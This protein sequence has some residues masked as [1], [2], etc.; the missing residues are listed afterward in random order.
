MAVLSAVTVIEVGA[1]PATAFCG[2]LLADAGARVIKIEP[3]DGDPARFDGPRGRLEDPERSPFFLNLNTGKQ[4]VTLDIETPAGIEVLRRL[5][6]RADVLLESLAPGTLEARGLAYDALRDANPGLLLASIT[7]Y[8]QTGPYRDYVATDITLFASSGAMYREGL[9]DREPL[10][11]GG[12][13][14]RTYPGNLAAGFIVAALF[15]RRATGRGDWLDLAEMDAWAAHPNQISR[16]LQTEYSGQVEARE[17]TKTAATTAAA[18]FGRGTYRC[19]DGFVTFLPLGDRHWPRLVEFVEDPTLFEDPRFATREARR[20]HR[21]DWEEIYEAYVGSHTVAEIFTAAQRAGIPSGPLNDARRLLADP[22]LAERHFFRETT[23][24]GAGALRHTGP[25][26]KSL[27]VDDVW[28]DLA[29]A[30]SLGA[31]TR[32][33]L[34]RDL[35]LPAGDVEAL[36]RSTAA[37]TPNIER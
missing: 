21:T 15:R 14:P 20:D 32:E 6:A 2:K 7:P 5:A 10:R 11:Y 12:H 1:G 13:M 29:P 8:G 17:D 19:L 25:V 9:P 22:Q 4:S 35:D 37:P 24:P 28:A 16:R 33:V 30:P 18:G 3:P 31:H 27:G 34:E 26:A 23:H 36:A